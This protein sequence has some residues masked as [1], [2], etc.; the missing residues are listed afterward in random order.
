MGLPCGNLL[1]GA[2]FDLNDIFHDVF[3]EDLLPS[4]LTL[5]KVQ[6][7]PIHSHLRQLIWNHREM[8]LGIQETPSKASATAETTL[9]RTGDIRVNVD[10]NLIFDKE[11]DTRLQIDSTFP[12][13]FEP[14]SLGRSVPEFENFRWEQIHLRFRVL[15]RDYRERCRARAPPDSLAHDP[16]TDLEVWSKPRRDHR[17]APLGWQNIQQW[18]SKEPVPVLPW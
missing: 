12:G 15:L 3:D 13:I 10:L 18:S 17:D 5:F 8:L 11:V 9:N 2:R 1:C 14:D 7:S 4:T 16:E 6:W